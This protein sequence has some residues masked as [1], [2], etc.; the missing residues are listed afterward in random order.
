MKRNEYWTE[1]EETAESLVEEAMDYCDQDRRAA[2]EHINDDAL[3]EA[4]DG[5]LWIACNAYHLPILQHS[6]NADYFAQCIGGADEILRYDGID[7]LHQV[8]AFYA[9]YADVRDRLDAA[10]DAYEGE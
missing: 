5:H 9:M 4:I 2:E 1:I 6:D 8:L 3:H 10:F 7:K